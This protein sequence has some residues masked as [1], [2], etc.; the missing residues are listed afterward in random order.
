MGV[1]NDPRIQ[2]HQTAI[3]AGANFTSADQKGVYLSFAA[4]ALVTVRVVVMRPQD[5]DPARR[6][7]LLTRLREM[8]PRCQGRWTK[9]VFTEDFVRG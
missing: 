6:A 4:N 3:C 8:A 9:T 7:E 2:P 1:W 5:A